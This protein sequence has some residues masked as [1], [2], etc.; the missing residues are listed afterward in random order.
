M[1]WWKHLD[2]KL[3]NNTMCRLITSFLQ[4][5]FWTKHLCLLTIMRHQG[6]PPCRPRYCSG[7]TS[8][9]GIL[10][11]PICPPLALVAIYRYSC[12]VLIK[13]N[14]WFQKYPSSNLQGNIAISSS[15]TKNHLWKGSQQGHCAS[16]AFIISALA[17]KY[18][19]RPLRSTCMQ[20]KKKWLFIHGTTSDR[21]NCLV[22]LKCMWESKTLRC[23]GKSLPRT[24]D[25]RA[26]GISVTCTA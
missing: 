25:Q 9:F 16:A 26:P 4:I 20:S 8:L 12:L 6:P 11:H 3:K 13:Q 23:R 14:C 24:L 5:L 7:S 22:P 18:L 19:D 17:F 15:D 1:I 10:R 21:T 2:R